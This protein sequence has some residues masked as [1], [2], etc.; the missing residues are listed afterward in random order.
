M[1]STRAHVAPASSILHSVST[2]WHD[3]PMVKITA[4]HQAAGYAGLLMAWTS[5]SLSSLPFSVITWK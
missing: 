4:D 2:S 3:G 5:P 1:R